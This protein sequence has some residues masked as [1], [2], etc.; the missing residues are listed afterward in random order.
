VHK[1][2]VVNKLVVMA[3]SG[4]S[5]S[6]PAR[7]TASIWAS[8]TISQVLTISFKSTK[9]WPKPSVTGVM[10]WPLTI[11]EH[12]IR[13]ELQGTIWPESSGRQ[14]RAAVPHVHVSDVGGSRY[15]VRT[16]WGGTR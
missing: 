16:R 10:Q 1:V 15:S 5:L 12:V 4:A 7:P 14:L 3:V 9:P 6:L 11:D 13:R 2:V 8:P